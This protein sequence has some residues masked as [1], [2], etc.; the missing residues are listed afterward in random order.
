MAA[1]PVNPDPYASIAVPV[2][3]GDPYASIAKPV[4]D[5]PQQKSWF[6]RAKDNFNAAT[7]GAKPGDG[8]V[9]SAVEDFG[10]GGGDV[11]R[12]LAHP[13]RTL[14]NLTSTPDPAMLS[15]A[16]VVSP[17]DPTVNAQ[18]Q[19]QAQNAPS[20]ARF[21]GQVGTGALAGEA[22]G[23]IADAASTLAGKTVS[24]AALLG[25]TPEA[26]YESAL[27]PSTTLSPADREQAIQTGLQNAIPVSKAGVEKLGDLISDLNQKIKDTINA[28][29]TRPIDPNAVATR[30][31][32]ARA[33]F[34]NQVNAQPD[35]NAIEASR[36]QFLAEQGA[37]P[38]MPATPPRPTGL[39]DAQGKPI[40]TGGTPAQP[41]TPAPPMNAADAQTM[42]QGTYSV[43]R[44]KY[45][46][47]GSASVE[48]QK[49]LARGLKEEIATQFPEIGNLNATESKLLDLQPI[50]ERAVNR[51]SN[52]QLIG[53]GTP[54][55]GAAA[56]AVAG[57][58]VGR[59]AMVMK[60][61]LDNP[62]VKSRLAIALSKGAKIPYGQAVGRVGAYSSALGASVHGQQGYSS[63][64]SPNQPT[65]PQP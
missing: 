32:I 22:A 10:A 40:M 20:T 4:A 9:K 59:V 35:L 64:D 7:Q 28:D 50:L 12:A 42:K 2:A 55:A 37:K 38:G 15:I 39:L 27:K 14:D 63:D 65:P 18:M 41:P 34:A 61:V 49:A 13:L 24:R 54:V 36:Q 45:G 16:H 23:P 58:G 52:H 31:D 46:E 19:Q 6:E 47:Q 62:A 33:K 56:D 25:K 17:N 21:L 43:L 5:V 57:P 60:A 53:I 8:A 26:A 44:G 30:A 29:P 1:A 3:G 11:I 51:I 48:A